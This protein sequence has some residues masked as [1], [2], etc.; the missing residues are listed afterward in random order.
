MTGGC[1]WKLNYKTESILNKLFK[2]KI[3]KYLI[4]FALVI[5]SLFGYSHSVS[6]K[7]IVIDETVETETI[8]Q[9]IEIDSVWAG[10]PVGFCLLTHG[11]RQYIAYYNANRNMVVGQRNLN[12]PEFQLHIMP[13]TPLP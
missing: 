3:M 5:V 13:A 6:Q 11:D 8:V 9:T 2:R 1:W 10:H 4:F 7:S 12:D